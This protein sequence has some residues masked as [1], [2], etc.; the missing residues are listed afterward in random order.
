M[1]DLIGLKLIDSKLLQILACPTCRFDLFEKEGKLICS[2]KLCN[3]E[4]EIVEGIPVLLSKQNR[5]A[6]DIRLTKSA[7]AK[8]YQKYEGEHYDPNNVPRAIQVCR[9]YIKKY[10]NSSAKFFLEAGCGT[11]RISLDTSRNH[12]DLTVVCLDITLDAL[13]IAKKLFEENDA[14]GFF[15]CGDMKF[16][17]FHEGVFDFIFSDGAIEHFKET[18]EALD[19]FFRVLR[20]GGRIFITVP[21]IPAMLTHGQL[22]GNIPNIPMLRQAFEFIHIRL[23]N[24]RFM[25]NGYEL[26]FNQAQ[27]N[28]LL[29]SFSCVEVGLYQT[30]HELNYLRNELLKRT[31]RRL[32]KNK[33]FCPLI[34]GFGVK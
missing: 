5:V 3:E 15:V 22:H 20:K 34:F 2:N 21:Y 6:K 32:A 23:L 10:M 17:P 24:R 9:F 12:D 26:S 29:N 1:K 28:S 13:L 14:S 16:L 27:L 11:A 31:V 4:F 33:L 8:V 18:H 7:W 19:E 25:K 30:F